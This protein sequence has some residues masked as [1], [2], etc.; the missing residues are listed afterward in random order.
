MNKIT[1][2]ICSK[3]LI[4]T[5]AFALQGCYSNDT[6]AVTRRAPSQNPGEN[7]QN[8]TVSSNR[9]ST[10]PKKYNSDFDAYQEYESNDAPVR[11][12][13]LKQV[14][15]RPV[16]NIQEL[17]DIMDNQYAKKTRKDKKPQN[18]EKVTC[19]DENCDLKEVIKYNKAKTQKKVVKNAPKQKDP[20]QKI[21]KT[22]PKTVTPV[23][24][25][26]ETKIIQ[27]KLEENQVKDFTAVNP[28]VISPVQNNVANTPAQPIAPNIP[29][30]VAAPAPVE[31]VVV[32]NITPPPPPVILPIEESGPTAISKLTKYD[33]ETKLETINTVLA[34][35]Y[36]KIKNT[37][38]SVFN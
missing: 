10:P 3:I 37:I 6:S 38:M 30:P 34:N 7:D 5:F 19:E 9:F 31:P 23:E 27:Q 15:R 21:A 33:R 8:N 18:I 4:I 11:L 17:N 24:V 1:L 20:A 35:Y 12:S 26:K 16:L 22:A 2:S 28:S 14:R 29:E 36:H 13:D 32:N 25:A